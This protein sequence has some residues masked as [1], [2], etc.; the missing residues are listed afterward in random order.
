VAG[1]ANDIFIEIDQEGKDLAEDEDAARLKIAG[2]HPETWQ[3]AASLDQ[4]L[5]KTLGEGG[6]TQ[7]PCGQIVLCK[8]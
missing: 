4:S 7:H 2:A 6:M 5:S 8:L 3:G 1:P